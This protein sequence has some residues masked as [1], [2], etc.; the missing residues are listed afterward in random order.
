MKMLRK[1]NFDFVDNT[2]YKIEYHGPGRNENDA[3]T[4]IAAYVKT[5]EKFHYEFGHPYDLET[6]KI[7]ASSI[8]IRTQEF[9]SIHPV[10]AYERY[11]WKEAVADFMMGIRKSGSVPTC[12]ERVDEVDMYK[13]DAEFF[14][15]QKIRQDHYRTEPLDYKTVYDNIVTGLSS[16]VNKY[17]LESLILGISGGIDSTVIAALSKEVCK[18]T[19]CKLIGISL[20]TNTNQND[21]VDAAC[22]VG[23]EFCTEYQKCTIEEEYKVL[24]AMCDRINGEGNPTSR[25]NIKA[26]MRM[27]TLFDASAKNK[28]IVLSGANRTEIELG[29][30]TLGGDSIAAIAPL[31][32]TWKHE[33]YELAKWMLKN[34]Y[35]DSAALKASIAL[36]PTDGNGV[37]AGG[38]MAQIAPGHTYEDVDDILMTYIEYKGHHPEEYQIAM[39]ELYEKYTKET[40]DRV[41]ERYHKS[42]FKRLHI[43]LGIDIFDACIVEA[44]GKLVY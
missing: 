12:Y 26:R 34:I 18:H 33:V 9:H 31:A 29:F 13:G 27:I 28:G 43:P 16:Y 37:Q 35:I 19:G 36:T 14:D 8:G 17:H 25:G 30:S 38:D 41:I 39:N 6:G 44:N 40:V 22:L 10:D 11:Y 23:A 24:D 42:A 4:V 15:F 20:M 5:D 7:T 3:Q 32:E 2:L 1:L 21:E